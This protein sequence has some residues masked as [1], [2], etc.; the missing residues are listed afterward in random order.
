MKTYIIFQHENGAV[1]AIPVPRLNRDWQYDR[2][3]KLVFDNGGE[4]AK[5]GA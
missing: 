3:D 4:I 1:K 5:T 2:I